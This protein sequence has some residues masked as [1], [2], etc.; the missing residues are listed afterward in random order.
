ML[1][2]STVDPTEGQVMLNTDK[3]RISS[4][5]PKPVRKTLEE[6][7]ALSGATLNQFVVQAALK[8]AH[9]VLERERI[10]RL[11]RRD[12]QAFFRALEK[13]PSP[14]ARLKKAVAAYKRA[15]LNAQ[16]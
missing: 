10:I 15:A 6:A 5:V 1:H 16:D 11:S 9:A 7:A 4:R 3:E 2:F 8:E 12:A 14:N 13:P